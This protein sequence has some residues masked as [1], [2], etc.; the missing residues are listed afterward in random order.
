MSPK[1]CPS[2]SAHGLRCASGSESN[3]C[4]SVSKRK[5]SSQSAS[6]VHWF[7]YLEDDLVL[8]DSLLLEKLAFFNRSAPPHALLL[9]HRYEF[10]NGH[11]VLTDLVS[12]ARVG[13]EWNRPTL[14]GVLL[15]A[16]VE[17]PHSAPPPHCP[18]RWQP[19]RWPNTAS[20]LVTGSAA[21]RPEREAA[22]G[23]LR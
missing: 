3:R 16:R 12:K 10:W 13:Y 9:P 23:R 1:L 22:T 20:G 17:K 11:K 8:R 15:S 18:P 6:R 5:A 21:L 4:S 19:Q 14:I 7:L 2:I